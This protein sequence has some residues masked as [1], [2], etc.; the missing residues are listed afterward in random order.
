MTVIP[1]ENPQIL[2]LFKRAQIDGAWVPE[3]WASR[4]IL[5]GNGKLFL[6]ER[7]LWPSGDFVTAHIIVATPFLKE[8][9]DLVK[10]WLDAH[11]Q[12]TTWEQQNPTQAKEVANQEIQRLTG[13]ALPDEVLDSAWSRLKVT[14]DPVSASLVTSA[15]AAHMAGFLKE[16]PDL[17]S[18]YD[19]SLLNQVLGERGLP[20]VK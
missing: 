5:E 10:S 17:A 14:Y 18:I 9:P 13:K 7:D 2:D 11:V 16:K 8:H 3:P 20:L 15:D 12:I 19:L 1:T 4:L 6:D